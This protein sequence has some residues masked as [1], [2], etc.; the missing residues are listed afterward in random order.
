MKSLEGLPGFSREEFLSAHEKPGL[1]SV[2]LNPFKLKADEEGKLLF[3]LDKSV[4]WSSQGYLLNER[5]S[6][7][8]DPLFHAGCYYVQEASSMFLEQALKQVLPL[9]KNLKILDLSAAPGGKSTHIISLITPGSLLVCNEVIKGRSLILKDNIIKWGRSN[10][11]ITQSDPSSFK[12]LESFFDC[13]VVDAPCSGSGLFRKDKEAIDEWSE[14]NVDLCSGRQQ[15][16]LADVLPSLKPGGVLIYSTCSYSEEENESI[17]SWLQSQFS[18]K[19]MQLTIP[20]DWGILESGGGFRFYPHRTIGEGFYLNVFQKEGEEEGTPTFR[21][22]TEK[23]N[24]V[25]AFP[26]GW[27]EDESLV[28][29]QTRTG[30]SFFPSHLLEEEKIIREKVHV[31]MTGTE[32]GELIRDKLVPSHSLALS[33]SLNP[34]I[35]FTELTFE[36]AIKYLQRQELS[37]EHPEK[38]WR[39]VKFRGKALGWINVLPNRI[40]NYYPKELRILRQDNKK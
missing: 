39:L 12:K 31:V 9:E 32:A 38:G 37:I 6:F 18:L 25:V 24:S 36:E 10:V 2:R 5:P 27:I 1:T 33:T 15:R 28:P 20:T 3:S 11:I 19:Q 40:N 16:I 14:A 22:K 30:I 21:R 8:F 35:P 26:K 7:T 23:G 34:Q 29:I 17:S 13:V 4:P